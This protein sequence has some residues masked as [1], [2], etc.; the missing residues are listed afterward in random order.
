MM[1]QTAELGGNQCYEEISF[2]YH[3]QSGYIGFI[4]AMAAVM[5]VETA[6]VSYLLYKWSPILHWIH[7]IL[8]VSVIVFLIVDLKAVINN[9]IMIKN[10][11]LF[12]KIG[13]RPKV[14]IS[15]EN[16]K[17]IKSGSLYQDD[18]K[19]KEVLDLS[20]F[21]LDDPTFEILLDQPIVDKTMFGKSKN[22]KRIFFSVDDKTS[23]SNLIRGQN[24]G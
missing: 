2:T 15:I 14:T 9:P 8:S 19:N 16:I 13:V 22:I 20:L 3:K 12:L 1:V 5:V 21:S 7:L 4:W 24:K 6:G 18:R 10:N 11:Q 23:F 17:E